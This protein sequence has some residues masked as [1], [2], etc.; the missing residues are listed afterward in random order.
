MKKLIM[1]VSVVALLGGIVL[2]QPVRDNKLSEAER[3]EQIHN[4]IIPQETIER[5]LARNI[6]KVELDQRLKKMGDNAAQEAEEYLK[7]SLKY[8][9]EEKV[10]LENVIAQ[11]RVLVKTLVSEPL[12]E[13][14]YARIVAALENLADAMR[15]VQLPELVARVKMFLRHDYYFPACNKTKL[16]SLSEV[17]FAVE[18]SESMYGH[19]RGNSGTHY[20]SVLNF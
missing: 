2:A 9:K 15:A 7:V 18:K 12:S 5:S 20:A 4:G 17:V 13:E 3:V 11:H 1:M 10:A 8:A 6:E 14:H 19:W 16:V